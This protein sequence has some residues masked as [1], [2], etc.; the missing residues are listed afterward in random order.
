MTRLFLAQTAP[1]AQAIRGCVASGADTTIPADRHDEF[2]TLSRR[3]AAAAAEAAQTIERLRP[4]V[5]VIAG[6]CTRADVP[7]GG[8]PALVY[9]AIAGGDAWIPDVLFDHRLDPAT[10]TESVPAWSTAVSLTLGSP[11]RVAAIVGPT[12]TEEQIA[13]LAGAV[14]Q[15]AD[16]LTALIDRILACSSPTVAAA[17]DHAERIAERWRLTRTQ[18]LRLASI[19][20]HA[21]I[22][23]GEVPLALVRAALP[24]D[25]SQHAP[26]TLSKQE[27]KRWIE[28]L[29][30]EITEFGRASV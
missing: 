29:E 21:A 28:R 16:S 30:Q 11:E 6:A 3:V 14:V 9:R 12:D 2:V 8:K 27:A 4:D 25:T 22:R 7:A 23:A 24:A 15:V 10:I 18:R 1:I 13:A 5:V 17:V 26:S 19:A 20:R